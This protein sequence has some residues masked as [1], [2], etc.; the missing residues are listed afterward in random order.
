[1][2][3]ANPTKPKLLQLQDAL[4]L[5]GRHLDW[6]QKLAQMPTEP[7]RTYMYPTDWDNWRVKQPCTCKWEE[8]INALV[9]PS[10][11]TVQQLPVVRYDQVGFQYLYTDPFTFSDIWNFESGLWNGQKPRGSR[12]VYTRTQ[13][14]PGETTGA[15]S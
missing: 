6:C 5:Y 13:L 10:D 15:Q 14:Q 4:N 7:G 8:A 2:S 9:R 11:E 1:M 3:D 12:V